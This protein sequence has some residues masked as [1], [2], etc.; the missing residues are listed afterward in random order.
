MLLPSSLP[1]G[2]HCSP[3]CEVLIAMLNLWA[4]L[5]CLSAF[6]ALPAI[7]PVCILLAFAM[8][9]SLPFGVHCSPRSTRRRSLN[10]TRESL[11]CLSAFTA[12][13]ANF[14]TTTMRTSS[15]RLHCLSAFTA[16]P[17]GGAEVIL[18]GRLDVFI[19][20]RRSL[21]SPREDAGGHRGDGDEVSIAFRRSLLSPQPRRSSG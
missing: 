15:R 13:P 6:T 5:H 4:G 1:F 8:G 7:I 2:V 12:L 16:L 21:L 11:H 19:A 20:F 10:L 9:S 17:A 14:R 18:C 3:R